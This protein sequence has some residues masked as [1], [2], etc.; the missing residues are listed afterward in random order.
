LEALLDEAEVRAFDVAT[1]ASPELSEADRREIARVVGIGAVKYNDLSK[2]RQTLVTFT[3]D[4][5]LS[6]TGNSGPYLQYAYARIQS[7]LRKAER[8]GAA[9]GAIGALLP[10][11]RALL[12]KLYDYGAAVEAVA[13]TTRP[14]LLCD[15]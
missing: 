9:P 1:Q 5:A 8:E 3:W 15:Y 2:D 12:T 10:A 6:L 13:A 4:K 7:I 14:H 11:E